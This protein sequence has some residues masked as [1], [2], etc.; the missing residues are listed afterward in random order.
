MQEKGRSYKNANNVGD[1]MDDNYR[2]KC[3]EEQ[4]TVIAPTSESVEGLDLQAVAELFK[5]AEDLEE[6]VVSIF[7]E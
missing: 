3:C 4:T 7:F 1:S 2:D 6:D 5:E